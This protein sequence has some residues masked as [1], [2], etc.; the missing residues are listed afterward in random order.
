MKN[1]AL[2][3]LFATLSIISFAQCTEAKDPDMAHYKRLTETKDA[4]GCSQCAMLALYFCSARHCVEMEDKRKVRSMIEACK[5]NIRNMGQPYCCNDLI[6][7]EPEWGK[8]ASGIVN[9]SNNG[10]SSNSTSDFEN[11]LN[12]AIAFGQKLESSFYSMQEV[13]KNRN[14]LNELSTLKGKFN[15]VEEIEMSFQKKFNQ[16]AE[17]V[18]KTI[19]SENT[20]IINN[21]STMNH[22]IGGD[23]LIGEGIALVGGLLNSIGAEDRKREY[24]E[25]LRKQKEEQISRLKA[26]KAS[27]VV[28]VRRALLETFPEGGLPL[29]SKSIDHQVIY[30]FSY[31]TNS[32]MFLRDK[33]NVYV[34]NVFPVSRNVDGTWIFKNIL[35]KNLKAHFNSDDAPVIL[36]YFTSEKDANKLRDSF[37]YLA[38]Q[39]EFDIKY[40]TYS[41]ETKTFKNENND[42][43]FWKN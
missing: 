13:D 6:N 3:I 17:A 7:K 25:L 28:E 23:Q 4:Q 2:I 41:N 42:E 35:M 27:Q 39:C 24:E 26:M 5:T 12:N 15:S 18:D 11:K 37:L 34:T 16:I 9:N 32:Y 40:S 8:E 1:I 10:S 29:S 33:P 14:I 30:I 38:S 21:V 19:E 43:D 22:L 31:S 36:G 20:A